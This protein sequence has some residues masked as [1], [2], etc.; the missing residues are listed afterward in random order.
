M[1]ACLRAALLCTATCVA[2][3]GGGDSLGGFSPVTDVPGLTGATHV[4]AFSPT[5]VWVLDGSANVHRFDGKT[6]STL[7]TP[8]TGG[9][10]CIYALSAT[11]VWLCAGTQVLAYDGTTFTASDVT[12]PTGLDSLTSLWASSPTDLWVTG[13]QAIV[14]RSN[15]STWSRMLVGGPNKSSVWGSSPTD[16]YALGTFD[17]FHYDGSAWSAVTL[18]GG[19]GGDGQVWGTGAKDV[20]VMPGSSSIA[21]FDGASWK[22]TQLNLI[23]ELSAVWGPAPNDVWAVGTAGA[24][25]HYDGSSWSQVGHQPI[26]APYL[27]Q[28]LDVHGSSASDIWIVGNQLG[29]GGSTGLIYHR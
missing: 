28:L 22:S 25:V 24:I 10:G 26:G 18:D 12:T 27:R 14:A 13:S 6:W 23:G 16:V 7:A 17:L 3:C 9:L 2:A 15:G 21:H 19:G 4:W 11:Q 5:N 8:S 1:M 20:W 29:S